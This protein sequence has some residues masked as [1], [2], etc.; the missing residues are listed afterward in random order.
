MAVFNSTLGPI[1]Q[2]FGNLTAS[3]WKGINTLRQ[4]PSSVANPQS[5]GQTA[6]RSKFKLLGILGRYFQAATAYGLRGM[7]VKMSQYNAFVKY[8]TQNVTYSGGSAT[9]DASAIIVSRGPVGVPGAMTLGAG[10]SAGQFTVTIVNNSDGN[11]ARSTDKLLLSI[12][13][14]TGQRTE[15]VDPV[16]TRATAATTFTV[17]LGAAWEGAAVQV[18]AF[19]MRADSSETSDN[20]NGSITI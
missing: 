7:A 8:N 9:I 15:F 1:K 20:N 11:V 19:F 12:Y 13:D 10:G 18:Y 14:A 2:S 16:K 6:Q 5:S 3:S 17:G 4:K